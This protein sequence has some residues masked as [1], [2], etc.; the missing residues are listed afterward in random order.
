MR[1]NSAASTGSALAAPDMGPRL[2][3][4]PIAKVTPLGTKGE[5]TVEPRRHQLQA[6]VYLAD[7]KEKID[8]LTETL[9]QLGVLPTSR[10]DSRL[11]ELGWKGVF[12]MKD[13]I[14]N[15]KNQLNERFASY[16][17]K[18]YSYCKVA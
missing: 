13:R 8:K 12:E 6:S 10:S 18:D 1:S 4:C 14:L 15:Q 3:H 16:I 17:L 5:T 11:R 7:E 9:G 2:P